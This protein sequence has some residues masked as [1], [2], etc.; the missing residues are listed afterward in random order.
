MTQHVGMRIFNDSLKATHVR[1]KTQGLQQNVKIHS[2]VFKILAC[3]WQM[4][5]KSCS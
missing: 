5:K 3:A 2:L 1:Q 4:Q